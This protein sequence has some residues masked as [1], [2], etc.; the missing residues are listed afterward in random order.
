M[1]V[2]SVS[3]LQLNVKRIARAINVC[4]KST[5]NDKRI[6]RAISLYLFSKTLES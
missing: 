3:N 5:I 6:A 2:L 4:F 1:F